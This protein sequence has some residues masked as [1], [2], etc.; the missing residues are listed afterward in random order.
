MPLDATLPAGTYAELEGSLGPFDAGLDGSQMQRLFRCYW[1]DRFNFPELV[2]LFT[3]LSLQTT[4]GQPIAKSLVLTNTR[5]ERLGANKTGAMGD[6]Y[7]QCLIY[8]T[9][10]L[11]P[12]LQE[13][14]DFSSESLET[15]EGRKWESTN[16]RV[17]IPSTV[18]M[19]T[20][21]WN[22]C[23]P[24]VNSAPHGSIFG[25]IGKI[26]SAALTYVTGVDK[27]RLLCAGAKVNKRVYPNGTPFWTITYSFIYRQRD[28]NEVWRAPRQARYPAGDPKEGELKYSDSDSGEQGD[29]IYVNGPAGIGGWDKPLDKDGNPLYAAAD[30]NPIFPSQHA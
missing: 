6:E 8:C 5:F 3:P 15:T 14:F 10:S 1:R 21:T 4:T 9:Y 17:D 27:H 26:N 30:F 23:S 13:D 20:I 12:W 2:N 18:F 24:P 16:T 29:P 22:Y 25:Y 7:D 19:P 28:W 11:P